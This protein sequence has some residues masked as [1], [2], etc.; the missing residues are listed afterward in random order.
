[1][2]EATVAGATWRIDLH[3]HTWFSRD[4]LN[5]PAA[6]V[7]RARRVGLDRLAV[8]DHNSLAGALA[9]HKLAPDLVILGE[10]IRTSDSGEVLAYFL[11]EEVPHGLPVAETL[12]RLRDQGAVISIPH[13]MDRFR[14]SAM[15]EAK[16]MA[17]IDRVDALEV[18]NARCLASG[19]NARRRTGGSRAWQGHH[20]RER[21]SHAGRDW[22]GLCDSAAV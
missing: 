21:W 3:T 10:E 20:G 4:S 16:A 5:D 1:M 7:A 8:T 15:G 2:A 14:H 19:D 6:L 13:P 22:G 17:I 18:F 9:A 11:T 12:Q